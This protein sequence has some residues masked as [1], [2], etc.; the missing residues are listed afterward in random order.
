MWGIRQPVP[1]RSR[2]RGRAALGAAATA[3]LL[4]LAAC[5]SGGGGAGSSGAVAAPVG[6]GT[7][8]APTSAAASRVVPGAQWQTVDPAEA[9]FDPAK[10]ETMAQQA[11]AA[12]SNCLLVTRDGKLVKEWYW[13]GTGP[14]SAQEVFSAT[15]S[16]TSALVGIAQA[17]GKLSIDEPASKYITEWQGT[18]SEKI[19]IKNLLSND[20][21]RYYDDKT[22]Y[23]DMA[24]GARDKTAFAIGLSQQSEPGTVWKYNN[25]AIQTLSR[26]LEKATGTSPSDYAQQKLLGP[27]GMTDSKMKKD[28]AGN[29]LTFMGLDSTCRDMARFGNLYLDG[30]SWGGAQV[31][32]GDWVKESTTPSQ[33]LNPGYGYLWW[34]NTRSDPSAAAQATGSQTDSTTPKQL[35][36]GVPE[37]AFFALGLG[38][39]HIAIFPDSG[40]VA[41]RLGPVNTPGAT[42]KFR[43]ADIATMTQAA[44][45]GEPTG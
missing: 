24:V 40:V 43:P 28:A 38:D 25:S 23:V 42:A 13:N 16:Y 7:T 45:A 11:E 29:T 21:G 5:S 39:Q 19:T 3:G 15:K 35:A 8:Q 12:G 2:R 17:E 14:D 6:G 10:L 44:V 20:S 9:G 32:P 37:D 26:V 1:V 18:P 34:L 41:V 30:G 4:G 22:D 36:P 31:V 33:Q 27:I